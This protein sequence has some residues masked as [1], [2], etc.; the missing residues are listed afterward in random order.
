M[1]LDWVPIVEEMTIVFAVVLSVS[2][3]LFPFVVVVN[4]S[5]MFWTI[6]KLI[7]VLCCWCFW[8]YL[9]GKWLCTHTI[10]FGSNRWSRIFQIS[11][12]TEFT[13]HSFTT[14]ICFV[15]GPISFGKLVTTVLL[16]SNSKLIS[17]FYDP[18]FTLPEVQLKESQRLNW[19]TTI[20]IENVF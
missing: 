6:V 16:D 15:V 14:E 5:L 12:A 11:F 17:F 18:F 10:S 2:S 7:E 13:I 19:M 9:C 4:S 1:S 8:N 3:L 20:P